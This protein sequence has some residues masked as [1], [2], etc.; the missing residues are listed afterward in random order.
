MATFVGPRKEGFDLIN[1]LA[2]GVSSALEITD[3]IGA[4]TANVY[5]LKKEKGQ[6]DEWS[7]F[8]PTPQIKYLS[9]DQMADQ[10]GVIG[11]GDILL[12][13][14]P[15]SL[16]SEESL[17]TATEDVNIK[18][19]WVIGGG[20]LE[21]KAYKTARITKPNPLLF[22]VMLERY[23]SINTEDLVVPQPGGG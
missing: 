8:L 13:N 19:F 1:D 22:N 4:K 21:N 16:H 5:R 6:E 14:I 23:K 3:D 10:G 2:E 12:T 18:L 9:L 20:G 11:V 17:Q 15:V 7:Q